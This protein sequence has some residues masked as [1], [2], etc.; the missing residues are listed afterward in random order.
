MI[1]GRGQRPAGP[2]GRSGTVP[3]VLLRTAALLFFAFSVTAAPA[4]GTQYLK[5]GTPL[6]GMTL[7]DLEG[8]KLVMPDSLRGKVVIFHFWAGWC[9]TCK[10]ELPVIDRLLRTYNRKGL[11]VT[12]VNVGQNRKTVKAFVSELKLTMPVYLD[13]KKKISERYEVAGVPR[14][15]ILDRKGV[16]RYKISG[17]ASE[18]MLKKLV[19]NLL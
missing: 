13:E 17:P 18:E 7:S 1:M 9:D 8:G 5:I 4:A 3:P 16:L 15:F 10:E 14:T 2:S 19:L 6:P 12:A 11:E